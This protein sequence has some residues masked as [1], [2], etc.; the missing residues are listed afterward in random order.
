MAVMRLADEAATGSRRA[1]RRLLEIRW[2]EWQELTEADAGQLE[3]DAEQSPLAQFADAIRESG[4]LPCS[5][6]QER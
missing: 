1:I 4:R 5:S 6:R 3:A 2:A